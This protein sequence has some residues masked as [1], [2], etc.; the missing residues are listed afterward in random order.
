MNSPEGNITTAMSQIPTNNTDNGLHIF[1][2]LNTA[3]IVINSL[4]STPLHIYVMLLIVNGA[5][6][7]VASEFFALNLSMCAIIFSFGT[8]LLLLLAQFFQLA[9]SEIPFLIVL[10]FTA[11]PLF[12]TCICVE[13]SL[14][15]VHP[16]LFLKYKPLR[17][18]VFVSGLVWVIVLSCG[19]IEIFQISIS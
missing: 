15:C 13:R 16:V 2:T 7:G 17:Y 18:R 4:L 9:G 12:Q 3:F 1:N 14:A 19:L 10:T 5:G 6:N 8:P 11:R